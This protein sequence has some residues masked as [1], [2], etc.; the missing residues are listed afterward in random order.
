M[1]GT[2]T[3]NQSHEVF[4]HIRIIIGMIL[5]LSV[6]RLVI[7]VTQFI[8][9]PGKERINLLHLGWAFFV[10]LSIIY[11]WWFEFALYKIQ[12]WTFEEYLLLICYAVAFVMLAAII[13]PDNVGSHTGLKEYFW[14]RRNVFY[15]L[16]LILFLIDGLDTMMKGPAYYLSAY[17]WYYPVRQALLISGTIGALLS[18]S[19]RYHLL[20][21]VFALVFQ[22]AWIGS[23][24]SVMGSK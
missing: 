9:H 23:F 15:A 20:F 11:F 10:F 4:V 24:F 18:A 3:L 6:S 1:N 21:V 17:G 12:V 5:A 8:Q 2:D 13:F 19:K 16:L 7:G 22:I 14:T